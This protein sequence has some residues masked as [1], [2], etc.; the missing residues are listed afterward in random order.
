MSSQPI[1]ET[2]LA[3][4]CEGER[5][6][7]VVSAP[8]GAPV[9]GDLGVVIVVGGPQV[10]AGSHRQ[11]VQLAR[12]L[13]AQGLPTLRFDV[14]GMGD[15]SGP[16][17]SFE[18]LGADIGAAIAALQQARPEVRRV[19]LWG[20]CDAASAALL[21][22]H[23]RPDP[24]VAALCLA[25]PWVRSEASLARTQVKHYYRQRLMQREFWLKLLRG[26]VAGAAWRDFIGSLRAARTAAPAAQASYQARMAQAWRA[27]DRPI[28]LLLSGSDYTAREFVDVTATDPAWQG[29]LSRPGVTQHGLALADHTFSDAPA[30]RQAER[31]TAAWLLRLNTPHPA[32]TLAHEH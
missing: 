5:L 8:E 30:A 4:P 12:H 15:S 2:V 20:L 3:F 10:R 9:T 32:A 26:G 23:E 6:L 29:A 13:A 14:R 27:F 1:T 19:A 17:R 18:H 31:L 16:Q 24:R 25:N 7:A 28:L 11:F 22:L 21:Y